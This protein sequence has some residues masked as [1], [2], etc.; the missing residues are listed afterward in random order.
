MY[1]LL[2]LCT[3]HTLIVLIV[4]W[5]EGARDLLNFLVYYLPSHPANKLPLH[6]PRVEHSESARRLKRGLTLRKVV[7]VGHS[8]GGTI[9]FVLISFTGHVSRLTSLT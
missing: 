9:W 7:A 1:A 3:A 8:L 5:H 2:P 6:L 4:H